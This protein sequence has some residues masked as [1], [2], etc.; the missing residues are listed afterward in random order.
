MSDTLWEFEHSIEC[1]VPRE[2][3]WKYWSNPANWDDP[4]A[5][6]EF[7]GPFVAGMRLTTVLPGQRLQSVIR[8]IVSECEALIEM[9]VMGATVQFRWRFEELAAERTKMT[10]VIRLVGDSGASLVEQAKVMERSVPQGMDRLAK[11]IERV[12]LAARR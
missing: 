10:Q 3:A 4:P 2:F 12:W 5:R 8:E 7:D 6:F 11:A 1:R 9:E